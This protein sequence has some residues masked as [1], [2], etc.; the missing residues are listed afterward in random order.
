MKAILSSKKTTMAAMG[1][2]LQENI[3]R[4]TKDEMELDFIDEW[5]ANSPDLNPIEN[6][7]RILKARVKLHHC[8]T[9]QELEDAVYKEW[10]A[11]TLQEI[12]ECI[13]GSERGPDKGQG[14]KKGKDYY[15]R[16]RLEECIERKGLATRY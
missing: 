7:W 8:K 11:I 1:L 4:W 6:L 12:N 5:P 14:G 15:W 2:D 9:Y 3:A 13:L 16:A 10:E